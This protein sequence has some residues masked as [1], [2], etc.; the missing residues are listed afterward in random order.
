MSDNDLAFMGVILE[1]A[2]LVSLRWKQMKKQIIGF[3]LHA[4]LNLYFFLLPH[5]NSVTQAHNIWL[6]NWT[7]VTLLLSSYPFSTLKIMPPIN[8]AENW[9]IY[10]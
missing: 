3:G 7:E 10:L 9:D 8:T 6:V 1:K 4:Y 2:P 5:L